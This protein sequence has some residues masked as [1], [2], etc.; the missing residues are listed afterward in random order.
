[1]QNATSIIFLLS[2]VVSAALVAQCSVRARGRLNLLL[3]TITWAILAV[4]AAVRTSG[5]DFAQYIQMYYFVSTGGVNVPILSNI[6]I[7]YKL[8][9]YVCFMLFDSA[10]SVIVVSALLTMA[11]FVGAFAKGP[12]RRHLGL[13]VF[14]FGFTSYFMTYILVR[15][16]LG[17]SIAFY[18]LATFERKRVLRYVLMVII[19]SAFHYA[20]LLFFLPVPVWLFYGRVRLWPFIAVSAGFVLFV[21]TIGIDLAAQLFPR[22]AVSITGDQHLALAIGPYQAAMFLAWLFVTPMFFLSKSQYGPLGVY[23]SFYSL[24]IIFI[25]FMVR[26]PIMS[27]IAY[28]FMPSLAFLLPPLLNF[29]FLG[30]SKW[31]G[32]LK[33]LSVI[34]VA[35]YGVV[36]MVAGL[37]DE[38]SFMLPYSSIFQR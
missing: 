31:R 23:F 12:S 33:F 17:L 29:N 22:F 3:L 4:P 34:L 30:D 20:V 32:Q 25:L 14:V 6:E 35:V 8:L 24:A 21:S 10:Q 36:L 28:V 38:L 37:T 5:A 13:T 2:I 9:N 27:R 1:M 16:M 11:F 15:N 7:G 18:A 19:G 26:M